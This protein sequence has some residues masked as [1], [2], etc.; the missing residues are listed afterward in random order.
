MKVF[1]SWS[2]NKSQ[3]VAKILKRW[4]P[5]II[6]S[7]EPYFSSSDIDK[8][9]RW[10]TDIAKE[11]QDA[12]FGILC[13][14][15]ENS[16]SEWLNFEAGALS[17]SIDQSRVCPFLIDLK[18]SDIQRSPIL[19]FQMTTATK[20]ET[21]KLFKSMNAIIDEGKLTEDV[22]EKT[23]TAF[24]PKIDEELQMIAQNTDSENPP[25]QNT[26]NT[27]PILEELLELVRYQ[28]KLL[29]SP[30]NLLP[31]NYLRKVIHDDTNK[32]LPKKFLIDLEEHLRRTYRFLDNLIS[33]ISSDESRD[34][35][36]NEKHLI[37][38][39]E[40]CRRS[41]EFGAFLHRMLRN[42]YRT[43]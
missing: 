37:Q 5:C 39:E 43:F 34:M 32:D 3:E 38:L 9:A 18:P 31:S 12:S 1:I 42:P 16:S 27:S 11:L 2:G 36:I 14:T 13:V 33:E 6:Q 40:L 20:D 22:L 15:K 19:Q 30:E 23:F 26:N 4:I 17:K 24:W 7:I 8:G 25:T 29:Q 41:R 21:L 35:H 28:H 10:S